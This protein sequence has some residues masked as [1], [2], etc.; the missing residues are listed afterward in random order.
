VRADFRPGLRPVW[1]TWLGS[2]LFVLVLAGIAAR[3]L[4]R[5]RGTA[6]LDALSLTDPFPHADL[7]GVPRWLFSPLARYDA[8]HYLDV[9]RDGYGHLGRGDVRAAF[10]PLYPL[11][12]NVGSGLD[13]SSRAALA[14]ACVV[15]LVSFFGAL[16][17]LWR[18]V[19]LEIGPAVA[20]RTIVLLAL[21]PTSFFFSA[22]YSES[23]FLLLSIAT[24]YAARTG[25]WAWA[26]VFTALASAERPPGVLLAVPLAL[27][28]LYGP[29]ADGP[30]P[31][32]PAARSLRERLRPRYELRPDIV[33]IGLAPLGV[34]AY[35]VYLG[36]AIGEPLAWKHVETHSYAYRLVWPPIGFWHGV[37]AAGHGIGQLSRGTHGSLAQARVVGLVA[38]LM[39]SVATV[40]ALR[41]LPIAYAVYPVMTLLLALTVQLP[42][43]P[44]RSLPRYLVVVFPLF[45]WLAIVCDR[46]AV[47]IPVLAGS[48][49]G[50]GVLTAQFA[51]WHW[52]A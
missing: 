10:F 50:L 27:M 32:E 22:P 44:L 48:I 41:R 24:F 5:S 14:A 38:L 52:I 17:L 35:T 42:Q 19:D 3:A 2:R 9:V 8:V 45:M 20:T 16:Y 47:R 11:V 21:F 7:G 26:G 33:W 28:Y 39:G 29:R 1:W 18:L 4:P 13:A 51:S 23:L 31:V 25:H 34:I 6:H 49:G 12:V 43:E 37:K 46:R 15:S 36:L 40:G 30:P